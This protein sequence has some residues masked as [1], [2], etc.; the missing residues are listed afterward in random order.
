[1]HLILLLLLQPHYTL[2]ECWPEMPSSYNRVGR[3]THLIPCHIS[4]VPENGADVA[5]LNFLHTDVHPVLR[6][7]KPLVDMK[8]KPF[9]SS[10]SHFNHLSFAVLSFVFLLLF[11]L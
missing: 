7:L 5:H 1:L 11:F 9:V 4:E 8:G 3:A 2:G 10:S 6:F